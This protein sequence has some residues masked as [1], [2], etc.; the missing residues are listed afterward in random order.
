MACGAAVGALEFFA[1]LSPTFLSFVAFASVVGAA[2]LASFAG[3]FVSAVVAA[4][5][6]ADTAQ[7]MRVANR[8]SF[9][10]PFSC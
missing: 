4:N 7:I 8:F 10:G 6:D 3:A 5:A 9:E 1:T 2:T